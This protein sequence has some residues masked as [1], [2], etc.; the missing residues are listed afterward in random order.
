MPG[1]HRLPAPAHPCIPLSPVTRGDRLLSIFASSTTCQSCQPLTS[2]PSSCPSS[3]PLAG[4]PGPHC[5]FDSSCLHITR[6]FSTNQNHGKLCQPMGELPVTSLSSSEYLYSH[7]QVKLDISLPTDKQVLLKIPYLCPC[8]LY[9][10]PGWQYRR[11]MQMFNVTL[12]FKSHKYRCTA[13]ELHSG[14]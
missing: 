3:T 1:L 7:I 10:L 11:L 8:L 2:P 5:P 6:L 13:H 4:P 12:S 14:T 9:I